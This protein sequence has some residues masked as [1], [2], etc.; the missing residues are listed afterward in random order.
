MEGK[1]SNNE[2]FTLE[3]FILRFLQKCLL[4][5]SSESCFIFMGGVFCIQSH[6]TQVL[7]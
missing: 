7:F 3:T 6:V 1:W 4:Q 5:L 2:Y